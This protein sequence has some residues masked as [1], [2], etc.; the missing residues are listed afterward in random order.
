MFRFFYEFML[1]F[2]F[3]RPS[4][5]SANYFFTLKSV[6]K[7]TERNKDNW[8]QSPLEVINRPQ[9]WASIILCFLIVNWFKYLLFIQ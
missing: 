6:Q 1:C 8:G 9:N 7:E 5:Y 4:R 3:N 2:R